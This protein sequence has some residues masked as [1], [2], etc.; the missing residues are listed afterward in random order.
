MTDTTLADRLR[1]DLAAVASSRASADKWERFCVSVGRAINELA[2][3]DA[4]IQKLRAAVEEWSRIHDERDLEGRQVE[5][6]LIA[7]DREIA[8]LKRKLIAYDAKALAALKD[9]ST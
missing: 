3:Q 7:K 2:A 1:D 4:K 5:A 6:V 8:D 9:Q